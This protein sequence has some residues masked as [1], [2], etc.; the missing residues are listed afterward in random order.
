MANWTEQEDEYIRANWEKCTNKEIAEALGRPAGALAPRA[1]Y[2]LKL[3][4]KGPSRWRR[5]ASAKDPRVVERAQKF[6]QLLKSTRY[7]SHACKQ[8]GLSPMTLQELLARD[9]EFRHSVEKIQQ[10]LAQTKLCSVCGSERLAED[11][12]VNSR[13]CPTCTKSKHKAWRKTLRGRLSR[14]CVS[15]HEREAGCDLTMEYMVERWERQD[16][17]CYYTGKPMKYTS[18]TRMDPD[19][20]SIDKVVPAKGYRQGNVVLCR[21]VVNQLKQNLTPTQFVNTCCRIVEVND[22]KMS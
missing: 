6:L 14:M 18:D 10:R 8:A 13:L 1:Y 11:F 22:A 16:G 5:F 20:V 21:L 19:L 7:K 9:A 15:A 2:V 4:K 17:C 3:P 12:R